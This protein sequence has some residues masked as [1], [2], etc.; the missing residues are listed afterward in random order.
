MLKI[1]GA[2]AGAL[3]AQSASAI[4]NAE[5]SA[6]FEIDVRDQPFDADW[7]FHRGDGPDYGLPSVTDDLWR[8]V[9]LPHD[10][11]IE[12]LPGSDPALNGIIR[13]ADIAPLW[14]KL[15]ELPSVTPLVI[16]PFDSRLNDNK[17]SR[18]NSNT[19]QT[20]YTVN[21]VG[22]YRK[23]FRLPK[24]DSD[25]CVELTF[26]GVY[27]NC[28]VWLNGAILAEHPHGYT[29]FTVDLTPHL[30]S[31]G[32]DNL[33]AV[34]VANLG[35]N[36]RWYSGSGIYRHVRLDIVRKARFEQ[37]GLTVTT[38]HVEP[39]Q[40]TVKVATR[41]I[42]PPREA[43]LTTYLRGQDGR[44]VAQT[45]GPATS[46]ATLKVSRPSLWSPETPYLYSVECELRI[47]DR[48]LDRMTSPFGI[49]TVQMDSTNGLT[50]NGKPYKLRG[51][52]IHHDNGLLGAV[53]IERAEIRKVELL[54]E[55]GFNALR[56]AHNPSSPAFLAACDRLGMLVIEES[57]DMWRL[58]KNPDDYHLYFDGW[59]KKDLMSVVRRGAN[60][61]SIIIWSIG[62]EIPERGEDDGVATA[63]MLADEVHRLDPTRPTTQAIPSFNVIGQT[64]TLDEIFQAAA[65]T[66][67]VAGYNYQDK[68][69]SS[70]HALYPSR[71]IVGTESYPRDLD[72][73]WRKVASSP[74]VL[75]DFVWSAMD[76]LGEASVGFTSLEG[77]TRN[78]Q[79]YPWYT[80]WCG[81]LDLIGGQRPQSLA[82]DV[83]WGV[84]NLEIAL[85][86]PL[87]DS[88]KEVQSE[89]GWRD[90]LLSW[91]WPG[92]EG[93]TLSMSVYT[94]GDRVTV[95]L[96]GRLIAEQVLQPSATFINRIPVSY[97]PGKLIVTAWSGGRK[98]GRRVLET[99]GPPAALRLNVDRP[100]VHNSR[101]DL[102]YVTASV[103]DAAG[104]VVPDAVH[105]VEIE[106]VGPLELAAFGNANPRG[107]ASF[108]Q[109]VAKTWHGR[110]L[111]I[112]RPNG[113]S[114][115]AA[116]RVK[117]TGLLGADTR[118]L[119]I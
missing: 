107:V 27:M 96:N 29:A 9:D 3:Y 16:G 46:P 10:W 115:Q 58:G 11:T 72:S 71:I 49:R 28:Q 74:Y 82:R 112:M 92:A 62:N 101:D 17:T 83:V 54:K 75:G 35:R 78:A 70:D 43:I 23:H 116:L 26:D 111:A 24:L 97:Q 67:D 113:R 41:T 69:Y 84:S 95:E 98:I 6:S 39:D 80:A 66:V 110:A 18:Q 25:S 12:D 109:R 77:D 61:P 94:R 21:G 57:F 52:C 56:S 99:A 33:I 48:V 86:R 60:H 8:T 119:V 38:P 102:A 2:A 81:D 47:G 88:R 117:S 4:S 89:W 7:R 76:Y 22:W 51:G 64:K 108:R 50:I 1:G 91:S 15:P 93:K 87:P 65:S 118:I 30:N 104:R 55:R 79:A 14:Q 34:R 45:S 105:I 36:S 42:A 106:T 31:D 114:G 37:C 59:W 53:A 63:K 68:R 73:I 5:R 32:S 19:S 40:A 44:I 20:A 100:R 90:E 85:Q 13:D 103:V